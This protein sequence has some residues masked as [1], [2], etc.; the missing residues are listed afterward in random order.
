MRRAR[1]SGFRLAAGKVGAILD[2]PASV[3][4]VVGEFGGRDK[5]GNAYRFN[6]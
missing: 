3:I 1:S 5:F 6:E 4:E 2:M